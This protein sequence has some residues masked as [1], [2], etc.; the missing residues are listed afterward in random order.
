MAKRNIFK[1]ENPG[2][3]I[4]VFLCLDLLN[5]MKVFYH[6]HLSKI[7]LAEKRASYLDITINFQ[8]V[9]NSPPFF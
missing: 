9:P 5:R 3:N 4:R 8:T 7:G 2:G 1:F 6:C